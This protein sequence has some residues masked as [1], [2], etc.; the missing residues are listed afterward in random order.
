MKLREIIS[1]G[2]V[3]PE[4]TA[5]DRDSALL[6]MLQALAAD[7]A[8]SQPSIAEIHGSLL[9][10]EANGSTGIGKGVAV[11]H[12]KHPAVTRMA[13]AVGRAPL[14][15][16]FNSLD[17]QPVFSIVLLLS[18]ADIPQI[19][20]QVMNTIFSNLQR[21][22]FRKN[23]RQADSVAKIIELLDEADSAR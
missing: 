5:K 18:P 15:L 13:G 20:L 3:I 23:L 21:D 16:D 10:R 1:A 22:A 17:R 8:I 11:P 14:G 19:H 6:E 12:S 9:K 2:S 4:L 7:G